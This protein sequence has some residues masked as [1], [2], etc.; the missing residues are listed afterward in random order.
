MTRH[1]GAFVAAE[2]PSSEPEATAVCARMV[3]GLG[4]D[5]LGTEADQVRQG[6]HLHL[7]WRFGDTCRVALIGHFDTVW[8]LGTLERW[9]FSVR[10]GRATGRGAFD[11]KAGIIQM[12]YAVAS[13]HDRD[14]ISLILTSDEEIGSPTSRSLIEDEVAGAAA[15]LI[16]EPSA[17]G[18]LKTG[19]KGVSL[20]RLRARGRS[21]HAGLEPEAGINATI[22]LAHQILAAAALGADDVGT[23]VTPTLACAGTT[24]NTVPAEAVV[25]LDVRATS[26]A[27]Q[28]RV[29]RELRAL[30]PRL[31]GS[32]LSLEGGPNRPPFPLSASAALMELAQRKASELGLEPLR[33]VPVGGGSDGNF[34]AGLGV[35]TLDGLGAVGD[36]AHAEGEFVEVATMP[37]RARLVAAL[38]REILDVGVAAD[39][40]V[41]DG[42]GPVSGAGAGVER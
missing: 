20:Y 35:P 10:D 11:M 40:G 29:D 19:R 37:G 28:D 13:L 41:A 6:E 4:H 17:G 38:V 39:V 9:P 34:T 23:T 12:L 15:A 5:L 1:L 2:S 27:E 14:G 24:S 33:G 3:A 26:A 30:A 8:P 21:A 7:R 32:G 31:A 16:L 36:G 42:P 18:A 22:E 25:H